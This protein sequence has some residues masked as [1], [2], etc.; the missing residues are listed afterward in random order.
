M[1]DRAFAIYMARVYLAQARVCRHRAAELPFYW[2]SFWRY[3]GWASKCRHE[4]AMAR[5]PAQGGL[6]A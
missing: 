2:R 1:N 6:F 3:L 5:E 4:A